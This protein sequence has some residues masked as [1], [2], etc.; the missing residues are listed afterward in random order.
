MYII[1]LFFFKSITFFYFC[2]KSLHLCPILVFNIAFCYCSCPKKL[3]L[4]KDNT[5]IIGTKRLRLSVGCAYLVLWVCGST[6]RTDNIPTLILLLDVRLI[7]ILFT[8]CLTIKRKVMKKVL[9]ICLIMLLTTISLNA[10]FKATPNGVATIDG[11]DFYVVDIEG[12]SASELYKSVMGYILSNFK[13]PEIVSSKQVDEMITLHGT[14]PSAFICKKVLGMAIAADV[15]LNIVMYF[16]D[17]K[18]R[19]DTPIVNSMYFSNTQ[20]VRFSGG[21]S[22]MGEGDI[23]MFKKNGKP[24]KESVVKAFDS[25]INTAIADIIGYVKENRNNDW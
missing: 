22:V 17:G 11:K 10:Q 9:F 16:K 6:F 13:N 20:Q 2:I 12:K 7:M 4:S 15:N 5:R 3:P 8:L 25:F 19:F 18:I 14:Y 1:S 21:A 23:N 24:N